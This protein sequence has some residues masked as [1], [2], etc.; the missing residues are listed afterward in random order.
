MAPIAVFFMI[1][2]LN[3][4]LIASSNLTKY[5][6]EICT[7]GKDE[8][9]FYNNLVYKIKKS[10]KS[11]LFKPLG[12]A[13]EVKIESTEIW[14]SAAPWRNQNSSE[15]FLASGYSTLK[16]KTGLYL[17]EGKTAVILKD[18]C[19]FF[20]TDSHF[21]PW[22]CLASVN[23]RFN[24]A[25]T[26]KL[27]AT[28]KKIDITINDTKLSYDNPGLLKAGITVK[29]ETSAMIWFSSKNV[30]ISVGLLQKFDRCKM[31]KQEDYPIY[32][33]NQIT[34]YD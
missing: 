10:G 3:I 19:K 14:H 6:R 18:K 16:H 26:V 5:S 21:Q 28:R 15:Y 27:Q 25:S 11:T 34:D 17:I 7:A 23:N 9:L 4:Q 20:K 31:A 24:E 32:I 29:G 12:I 1:F 22:S 2:L 8:I 13:G 30:F 33:T